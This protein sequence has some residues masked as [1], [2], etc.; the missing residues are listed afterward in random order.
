[1]RFFF[2]TASISGRQKDSEGE[3]VAKNVY[4]KLR[5]LTSERAS[6]AEREPHFFQSSLTH[7]RAIR[8]T[9]HTPIFP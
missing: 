3:L 6:E 1:M 2:G 7:A 9:V 4:K 8:T 5:R